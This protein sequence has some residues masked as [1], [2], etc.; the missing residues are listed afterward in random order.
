MRL[1]QDILAIL[2]VV[3]A[4][5]GGTVFMIR[6][7]GV[8]NAKPEYAT[9]WPQPRPLPEFELVDHAGQRFSRES[10][11]GGWNL[12]FF[13]FT[14]CPDICPTTLQQ[15]SLAQQKI[16]Q[17]GSEAPRIVLVSVDPERDA[18]DVMAAYVRHFAGDIRG[19]SGE[20]AELRKLTGSAGVFFQKS[21]RDDG[22]YSVDHSAVVL[23]VDKDAAI[24]A[25][26]SGPHDADKFV[27]DV[28]ILMD[29]Q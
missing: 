23:V 3:L 16:V 14:H 27:H 19:V 1:P 5:A 20:L 18:A 12:V 25:S 6:A 21:M 26:F 22:S 11:R 13:G 4:F 7:T 15:L 10:L 24:R 28:P 29:Y 2:F 17:S 8:A 9:L